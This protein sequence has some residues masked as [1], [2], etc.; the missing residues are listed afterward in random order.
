MY[1]IR[2]PMNYHLLRTNAYQKYYQRATGIAA[3][4]EALTGLRSDHHQQ[5]RC[6]DPMMSG[7]D[8]IRIN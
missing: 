8:G 6:C 3:Q 5:R 4:E 2:S 1:G 7:S